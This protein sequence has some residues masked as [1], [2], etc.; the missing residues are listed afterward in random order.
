M[1]QMFCQP[2]LGQAQMAAWTLAHVP[3]RG[4]D[5]VQHD[6]GGQ[7]PVFLAWQGCWVVASPQL[8]AWEPALWGPLS[9]SIW[10]WGSQPTGQ[11]GPLSLS[12][13]RVRSKH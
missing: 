10:L 13:L 7:A 11:P 8:H 12:L 3:T 6:L 4:G 1:K 9:P 5:G 2:C